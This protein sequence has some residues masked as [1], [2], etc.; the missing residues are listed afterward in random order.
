MPDEL[1]EDRTMSGTGLVRIVNPPSTV[2]RY[3]LYID[4]IRDAFPDYRSKK[5]SPNRQRIATMVLVRDGYVVGEE[6]ID[7]DRRRFDYILDVTGQNLIAI[8]C[9]YKGILQSFANLGSALGLTVVSVVDTIKDYKSLNLLWDEARFV[10]EGSAALQVRLY[11]SKY[12]F[13][14]NDAMDEDKPPPPPAPLPKVPPN[15]PI[16]DLSRPYPNDNV[17]SPNPGDGLAPKPTIFP[18]GTSCKRYKVYAYRQPVNGL[19]QPVGSPDFGAGLR[20]WGKVE[21]LS[22]INATTTSFTFVA[23][24]HGNYDLVPCSVGN[25]TSTFA[26]AGTFLGQFQ[27]RD[28]DTDAIVYTGDGTL[29]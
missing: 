9:Q 26:A 8:K 13:C 17:T 18:Y 4:V 29:P 19:G 16:G 5:Y 14:D 10:C 6:P 21:S 20:V 23:V 24:A 1:V 22:V 7:Y 2:R 15:T 12:E 28:G 11:R 3:T 25:L 27:I